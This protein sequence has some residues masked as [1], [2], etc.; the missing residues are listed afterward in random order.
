M[1]AWWFYREK[2]RTVFLLMFSIA[3]T[4]IGIITALLL[5]LQ[6][7]HQKLSDAPILRKRATTLYFLGHL[8]LFGI[9]RIQWM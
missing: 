7:Q 3:A 2:N 8:H 1:E 9:E 5:Q 4:F 6:F